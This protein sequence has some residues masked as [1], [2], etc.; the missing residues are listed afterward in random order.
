[1]IR[2]DREVTELK[3]ISDILSRCHTIRVGMNYDG[4]PY[5]VPLSFGMEIVDG[6]ILLYVHGAN[7]GLKLELLEKCGR[8]CV[9]GDVFH[10]FEQIKHGITARYE[11]VIGFGSAERLTGAE[12]VHGL[13]LLNAH[14]G[15]EGYVMDECAPVDKMAVWRITLHSVTGKRNL[16]KA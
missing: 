5:I 2:K 3:E 16:K 9:E 14:C 6:S 11:S 12:A 1:M 7:R 8:V 15:F 4:A 13:E 10:C